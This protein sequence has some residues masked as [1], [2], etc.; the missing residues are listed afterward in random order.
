MYTY[1]NFIVSD[2]KRSQSFKADADMKN[3]EV[4][5]EYVI[6]KANAVLKLKYDDKK[7]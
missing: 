6:V 3:F 5:F 2:A 7:S 4:E 1:P